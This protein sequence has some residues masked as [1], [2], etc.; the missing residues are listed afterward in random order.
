MVLS[1]EVE[2]DLDVDYELIVVLINANDEA[3]TITI[4]A[5]ANKGLLLHLVQVL[6]ADDVVKTSRY[7]D[8]GT[9][10]V[11]ARTTAVFV[12]E[13]SAQWRMRDL[14]LTIQTMLG[15]DCQE[16][17]CQMLVLELRLAIQSLNERWGPWYRG[18]LGHLDSVRNLVSAYMDS[19]VLSAAEGQALLDRVDAFIHQ[20]RIRY[21]LR[22]AAVDVGPLPE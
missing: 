21:G 14:I 1:D 2:P 5:L 7:D 11:P 6:S 9:F 3:Q 8:D 22:G 13:V 20:I 4:P 15:P 16:G 12:D 17:P 10:R 18:A 19:G